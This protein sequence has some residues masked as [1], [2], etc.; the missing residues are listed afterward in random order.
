MF[1]KTMIFVLFG[2]IL[3]VPEA[4]LAGI[5]NAA[6]TSSTAKVASTVK[7]ADALPV[8]RLASNDIAQISEG[9]A[10][11]I[12]NKNA[13]SQQSVTGLSKVP[14]QAWLILTALFCFVMRS[15]RRV[16]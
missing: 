15:S 10:K 7:I 14:P 8:I 13:V 16:V 1:K 2:V 12:A 9:D 11:Y 4:V 3:T 6:Q 5:G